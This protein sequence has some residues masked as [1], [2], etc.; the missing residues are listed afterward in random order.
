MLVPASLASLLPA[1]APRRS[2][3]RSPARLS[4]FPALHHH[5]A[6]S[7]LGCCCTTSCWLP[8]SNLRF[9]RLWSPSAIRSYLNELPTVAYRTSAGHSFRLP[10]CWILGLLLW[11][12]RAKS[13]AL[14]KPLDQRLPLPPLTGP[15]RV[16]PN[17]LTKSPA[18]PL[19]LSISPRGP[20]HKT[21]HPL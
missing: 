21:T 18:G 15:N 12:D 19:T 20:S 9:C 16:E 10:T 17:I 7:P 1:P 2:L 6:V 14:K 13:D 5:P 8:A 3:A 4:N 11:P